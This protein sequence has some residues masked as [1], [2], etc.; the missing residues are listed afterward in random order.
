MCLCSGGNREAGTRPM[1]DDT[2]RAKRKAKVTKA[3]KPRL[4]LV[5]E[6][7]AEVVHLANGQGKNTHGLTAKQEAFAQGVGTRGE[8]LA[9]AYRAAYDAA[10]MAPAT[11]HSEAC[12]L[13]ANPTISARIN[14]L[15]IERQGRES[16]NAERIKAH[17][18]ERLHQESIDP[19]SS[20]AAR[21]RAL[22]LLG[23]LGNVQAFVGK[24][25]DDDAAPAQ[26]DI[27]ATL[28]ARLRALLAKAG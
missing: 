16:H 1:P 12:R 10:N 24:D 5:T 6:Q 15:V 26:A 4:R 27:A 8:T 7:P 19:D 20:P 18:I 17:V 11:V 21:I 22:E 3:R 9:D 25:K 28:E 14:R 23:R 2:D 13:M